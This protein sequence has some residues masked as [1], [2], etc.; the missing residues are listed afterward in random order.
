[1]KEKMRDIWN[2]IMELPLIIKITVSVCVAAV[3][4]GIILAVNILHQD[5]DTA[6]PTESEILVKTPT[7]ATETVQP[8]PETETQAT[9]TEEAVPIL[10]ACSMAAESLEKNLDVYF[11]DDAGETITDISFQVKVLPINQMGMLQA[12]TAAGDQ[13]VTSAGGQTGTPSGNQAGTSSGDQTGTSAGNQTGTSAGDQ[14]GTAV[15]SQTGTA[16]GVPA[17]TSELL[18]SLQEAMGELNEL[19]TKQAEMEAQIGTVDFSIDDYDELLIQKKHAID[20]YSE[21]LNNAPG[22]YYTD[23]DK[24]GSILIDTIN[25]G[26][27]MLCFAPVENPE[28]A[29]ASVTDVQGE[30]GREYELPV[31]L[32]DAKEYTISVTVKEQA[33]TAVLQYVE[34]KVVDAEQAGDVQEKHENVKVQK[35]IEDTVAY[36]DEFSVQQTSDYTE[37]GIRSKNLDVQASVASDMAEV[38]KN[39]EIASEP[40]GNSAGESTEAVGTEVVTSRLAVGK[41]VKLYASA[42]EKASSIVLP[43]EASNVENLSLTASSSVKKFIKIKQKQDGFAI[44]VRNRAKISENKKG[45]LILSGLD[46][47]GNTIE[48]KCK[49]TIVGAETKLKYQ[50]KKL[51]VEGTDG[52]IV[53]ATVGNYKSGQT[54]YVAQPSKVTSYYGWRTSGKKRYFYD[55]SG[56]IVKGRQRIGGVDYKFD[57]KTGE[58]LSASVGV[59]VSS[60]QGDIDWEQASSCVTS[61]MIR[62]GFRGTGG[63][64]AIDTKYLA[65]VSEARKNGIL[66]GVYFHSRAK[67]A[68]EAVEEASLAVALAKN[69]GDL[70]LPVYMEMDSSVHGGMSKEQ[71]TAIVRKFCATVQKGGYKSGVAASTTDLNKNLTVSEL[72][73]YHVWCMQY[74]TKCTY[75][76][77]YDI[78]QY[79]NK[80]RVPGIVGYVD[81]NLRK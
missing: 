72:S 27:Y 58:L 42:D 34:H 36:A 4:V 7:E 33:D 66:V 55:E 75:K 53:R 20:S 67:T 29:G 13:A 17:N 61:A 15:G 63:K 32:Y 52:T 31:S 81:L 3:L 16:D 78:W 24:N 50:K 41:S 2:K 39:C 76:G 25:A 37:T 11:L 57:S 1:M 22:E 74:H 71:R 46:A 30:E 51:Y 49:M 77:T 43:Y 62:C 28:A 47:E 14:T 70:N 23:D 26:N 69:A 65:N 5:D 9:E 10:T 40:G 73:G 18:R 68:A 19:G 80:G 79:T 6:M 45:E 38:T 60:W 59:D 56:K 35:T 21:A 44:T 48:A 64:L 8:E 54:Y 12:G